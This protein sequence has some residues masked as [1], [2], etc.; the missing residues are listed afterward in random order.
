MSLYNNILKVSKRYLAILI[1]PDKFEMNPAFAK[2]YLKKI[3]TTATHLFIGGSTDPDQKIAVVVRLIK[4]HT[5]LPVILFPGNY[6]QVTPEADA[7]LFLSLLSGKNAEYLIGQQTKAARTIQT[8]GLEV[9]PTA[10][11][12]IDGG[13]ETAVQKVSNTL[14]IPQHQIEKIVTIALAGQYLG[15]KLIYLEAGSGAKNPI[16]PDIIK[17]VSNEVTIPLLVGG[18]IRSSTELDNA[19]KA[20]ATMVVIGTAFENDS[21]EV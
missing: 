14:P 19:Y 4:A 18:G 5:T 21:W 10:Y 20:G 13:A 6:K 8:S 15:K 1:D 12:L 3:P 2:A 7:I 16:H 11:I 17:A 9:I